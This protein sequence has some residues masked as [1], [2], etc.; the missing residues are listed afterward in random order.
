MYIYIYKIRNINLPKR[1]MSRRRYS[2][3]I[4]SELNL[5]NVYEG[6]KK[7]EA[8]YSKRTQLS[9]LNMLSFTNMDEPVADFRR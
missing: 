4:F 5:Y 7:M 3:N 2:K 1:Y 8:F 6:H 9:S